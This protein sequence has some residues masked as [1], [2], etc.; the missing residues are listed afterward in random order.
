MSRKQLPL[1]FNLYVVPLCIK[2]NQVHR[3][4]P[5]FPIRSQVDSSHNRAV[6]T[7]IHKQYRVTAD[8]QVGQ[9]YFND[10]VRRLG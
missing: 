9:N 1:E 3:L 5:L 4:T 6:L 7:P 2:G 10:V 8:K